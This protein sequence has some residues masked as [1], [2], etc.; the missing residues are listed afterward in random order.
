M[1]LRGS[2]ERDGVRRRDF[3]LTAAGVPLAIGR[4]AFAASDPP[5][6]P[7]EPEPLAATLAPH[8]MTWLHQDS[9]SFASTWPILRDPE[10]PLP[11]G[12]D[13]EDPFIYRA[14][15]KAAALDTG[16]S[17]SGR[18]GGG[19]GAWAATGPCEATWTEIP[20]PPS[21]PSCSTRPRGL[22]S[23]REGFFDFDDPENHRQFVDDM[24]YLDRSYWSNPRYAHRFF[25]LDGRPALFTWNSRNFVG[26]W[27]ATVASA[28]QQAPFYLVVG[29]ALELGP[30][31]RPVVRFD[32][33]EVAAPLDAISSYG[34]YDPRFVPASGRLDDAYAGRY[35]QA[36][37]GWAEI[38]LTAAP[39]ARLIPPLQFAFD[40]H[41]VRPEFRHPTLG[42]SGEEAIA[43]ARVARRLVDDARS[44]DP[45]Y[46][47]VL[48]IVFVVS[49][50][51]HIEG[52]AIEWTYEH[53]YGYL[54]A[55]ISA[56]RTRGASRTSSW[57]R[58]YSPENPKGGAGMAMFAR[59]GGVARSSSSWTAGGTLERRIPSCRGRPMTSRGRVR[60][61][62]G[63]ADLRSRQGGVREVA[64]AS[65]AGQALL[66]EE[67]AAPR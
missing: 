33:A 21:S 25:R 66:V 52:S 63:L 43:V 23:S 49:W 55:V 22:A 45:R 50:N 57:T 4:T 64:Q 18:G 32:L 7:Q 58:P 46:R 47:N 60:R 35:E 6:A 5:N 1:D 10:Y 54:T 36:L 44:G 30:D 24:A 59:S 3:V 13:S 41:Y 37:R 40:D 38:L 61:R 28:R 14:H 34:I 9:W 19:R 51:E 67:R 26:A 2:P 12:Y 17:G 8:Y 20:T 62:R 15:D 39:H 48:P 11:R 27:S 29:V 53:P 16:S 65:A 56:F 31:G 42:S